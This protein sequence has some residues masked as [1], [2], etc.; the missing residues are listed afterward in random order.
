MKKILLSVAGYDPTSGAGAS[1]DLKVFHHLGFQGM[2]VLT[3]VTSQNTK[4]VKKIHCLSPEFIWEQY[5]TLCQDVSISGIKVG[6][7]GCRKNIQVI[8]KILEYNPNIPKV[9]DPVFKSSSG[10]WLLEKE[11]I[12]G[13]ISGIREKASLLTPNLSEAFLISG[14]KIENTEDMKKAART[15]YSLSGIPCLLKGGHFP[16]QMVNLLFDGKKFYLFKKKK[17][18]KNVHGTGC[19]LSSSLL[20]HLAKGYSLEKA[21]LLATE[22]THRAIKSSIQIGKGQRII[23]FPL[24]QETKSGE[25]T[26]LKS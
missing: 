25:E 11:S 3:S 20:A 1:L 17:L 13:Y 21:C 18:K 2:A 9:V 8:K 5:Q 22:L 15:I 26:V 23:S 4:R 12:P 14:I 19:Y 10:A 24:R 7:V 6:M 16:A